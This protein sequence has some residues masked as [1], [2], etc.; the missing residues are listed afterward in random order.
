MNI[1]IYW[2]H[3]INTN[4]DVGIVSERLPQAHDRMMKGFVKLNDNYEP[5]GLYPLYKGGNPV[6]LG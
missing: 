1:F 3:N 2:F 5:I 4:Q 6:Y